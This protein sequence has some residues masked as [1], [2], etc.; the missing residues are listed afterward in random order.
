M[1]SKSQW[2]VRKARP[3]FRRQREPTAN[4]DLK[5]IFAAFDRDGEPFTW[6]RCKNCTVTN[7]CL[8]GEMGLLKKTAFLPDC[9]F[10]T[11]T[12]RTTT[13]AATRPETKMTMRRR[14]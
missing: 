13:M 11:T 2:N 1:F 6:R 3:R 5:A 4:D 12:T 8:R 14:F 9:R 10:W 7:K